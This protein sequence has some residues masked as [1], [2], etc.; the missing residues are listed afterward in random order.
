M[1]FS[2]SVMPDSAIPWTAAHQASLS[3]TISQGLLKLMSIESVMPSNHFVLCC[4]LLLPQSFSASRSFLMSRLFA[5][6]GRSIRTSVS[7]LLT[8]L[9]GWFPLGLTELISLLSKRLSRVFSRNTVRK[10][11]LFSTQPSFWSNSH[12]PTTTGKTIALT[13][14]TFMAMW[15]LCF[16]THCLG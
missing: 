11:Y 2:H 9:Q 15:C 6:D 10:H 16:L 5:P 8:N 12:I 7:V 1:L 13:P 4:R 3:S 14:W